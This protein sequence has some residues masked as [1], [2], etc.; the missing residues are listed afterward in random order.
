MADET[1]DSRRH[2]VLAGASRA[3]VLDLLRRTQRPMAVSEVAEAVGL[4]ANTVRTH[5][6]LLTE[7]GYAYRETEPPRG[8]GRPRVVYS[9]TSTTDDGRNYRLLAEL[10]ARY[11]VATNEHPGDAAVEAGRHWAKNVAIRV[12]AERPD[13]VSGPAA[14]AR[15]VHLLADAGFSPELGDDGMSIYLH[16]CPFRELAHSQRDVVCG[17]HLGIIQGALNELGAPVEAPTLLPFVEPDLCVATLREPSDATT[18]G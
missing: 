16:S 11:L 10:L 14:V 17:A 5:L 1:L 13:G 3:A 8:P 2:H 4:H 12:D 15:V 9:A 18:R 7:T 6:D